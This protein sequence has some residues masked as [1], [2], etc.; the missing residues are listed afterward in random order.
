MSIKTRTTCRI[1]GKPLKQVADFGNLY[2]SHFYKTKELDAPR[3]PLRI[4]IGEESGLLQLMDTVDR[5]LMYRQYWY[6]SGTNATMT[7]QLRDIVSVVPYWVRLN[8]GDI[9]LDIGCN[10]GTLLKQYPATVKLV[11]VG[12]DPAKNIAERAKEVC[13]LYACDYFNK[14]AYHNLTNGRKAKVITSIAMF[15]DLEDPAGFIQDIKAC[16]ADDGVWIMQLSYTPLMLK[17]NA[18][19]NVIHEHLEYYSLMSVNFLL[20]EFD[21]KILD[22]DFND[23]N[24]GS[25][26][27][28]VT[29]ASNPVKDATLFNKDIG[30]YRYASTYEFEKKLGVDQENAFIE[31]MKRVESIKGKTLDLL[32]ML[33][34]QGKTVFGYGASTKGNTL[35]QYYGID[36]NLVQGIAERQSQKF[37]TLT[38]GSWI[39]VTSEEEVRKA[40]PDYLLVLPWH[41]FNEFYQREQDFLK[42]GGKFIVPL[43]ELMVIG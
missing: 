41:F 8:D 28:V 27:L 15:Y 16:L 10:D 38:P 43:P 23:T 13:D 22:V 24:A 20:K 37:G 35:L 25:F 14:T 6:L 29:K 2:L 3:G 5:D 32:H 39:P 17:Q 21:M 7:Q 11:K 1:S 40:K 18:F 36:S 31:F 26:R 4:G 30:E 12:I 42:S 9:V 34:K 19:D 33:K